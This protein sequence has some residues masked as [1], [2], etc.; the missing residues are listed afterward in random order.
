MKYKFEKAEKNSVKI[1]ITLDA[2]EW[3]QARENAYN[4]TK[5]QYSMQGFRKG[6]VPMKVLENAY[7]AGIF[8]EDAI[9]D[10][11]P[12]YYGEVLD[13][14]PSIEVIARPSLDIEKIDEK[15]ITLVAVVPVKPEVKLGA[16]K[17]IKFDKV[18]YNVEDKDIEEEIKRLRERNS[19]LIDVTDRACEN[20]DNVII[21]YSG[22]VDGVKFDGGTAEKQPLTLGSGQFIP[23]F[24]DQVV[25]MAIGEERDISVKFP[26]EYHA[27]NLKGKD[28]VFHVKLHE[29]KKTELP[30][31]N[32]EFI[33]EAAGAESLDAYKKE[34]KERL[35][36][37][38]ADRAERELEN[39]I[40]KFIADDSQVELN[41]SVVEDQIDS[42]V[43]DM[44]YRMMYQGLKLED[45]LKYMNITMADYRKNFEGQA[46]EMLKSQFVIGAI[47]DA[48]KIDATD[49]EVQERINEMAEKQGKKPIDV[50]EK[51]DTKQVEYIKNDIIIK[52]LFDFL[53]KENEI[54]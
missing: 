27:E 34:T 11:F 30:E 28:A 1:R 46:R 26:E 33:K 13:K 23:G 9:N 24:E 14:E 50:S 41:D 37:M 6:K 51:M 5:G 4:K 18:E 39:K 16:Y 12:K 10:C 15:G 42:M 43:Q 54:K 49:E 21:D 35:E 47:L 53:K 32:D 40:I 52:K 20:G 3:Q 44:E 31:V 7:G 38:N 25:G 2:K 8:F 19:R 36:K 45:Y 29:I 17:G 48:E 22:S